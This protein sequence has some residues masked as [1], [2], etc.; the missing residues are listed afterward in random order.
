MID[1]SRL[2]KLKSIGNVSVEF[3]LKDIIDS[4]KYKKLI[5]F[6]TVNLDYW[7]DKI[8]D[9]EK[10]GKLK[11]IKGNTEEASIKLIW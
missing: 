10:F 8:F 4:S 2:G 3:G 5:K 1:N 7:N 6:G 9:K 11:S